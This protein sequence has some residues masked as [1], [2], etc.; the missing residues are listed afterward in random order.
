MNVIYALCKSCQ[1]RVITASD[2][3]LFNSA[4][5]LRKYT[6]KYS[7][8]FSTFKL[9]LVLYISVSLSRIKLFSD[10]LI[11]Q[12]KNKYSI[13]NT[14]TTTHSPS[15]IDWHWKVLSVTNSPCYS[16]SSSE[17]NVVRPCNFVFNIKWNLTFIDQ[18]E[19]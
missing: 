6:L 1:I 9:K 12:A 14:L 5:C 13:F 17:L 4:F 2:V 10:N 11:T 3:A 19:S 16:L 7:T 18:L 8:S 15:I